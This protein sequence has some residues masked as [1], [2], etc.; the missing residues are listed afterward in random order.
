MLQWELG[1]VMDQEA[2]AGM[3]STNNL[4]KHEDTHALDSLQM[5]IVGE[6]AFAA[7]KYCSSNYLQGIRRPQ[8]I[9]RTEFCCLHSVDGF[10]GN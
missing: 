6:K 3:S 1:N 9:V 10:N 5:A 7:G 2:I 8:A 4:I